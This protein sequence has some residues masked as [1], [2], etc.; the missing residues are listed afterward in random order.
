VAAGK[1]LDDEC[2]EYI[3]QVGSVKVV[4]VMCT[5]TGNLKPQI[6]PVIHA[7]GPNAHDNSN[8]QDN[9]DLVQS[10]VLCSL[11]HAEHVLKAASIALPAISSGLFGVP[12]IDEA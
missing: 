7:V 8:R 11:E 5:T 12:K 3:L 1:E 6:K 10:S 4:K 2:N 9:F